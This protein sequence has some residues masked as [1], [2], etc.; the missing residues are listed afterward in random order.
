MVELT[1]VDFSL[2]HDLNCTSIYAY[3]HGTPRTGNAAFVAALAWAVP[4]GDSWRVLY[5]NQTIGQATCD[6]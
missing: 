3:T 4:N 2:H 1:C 5:L 6:R